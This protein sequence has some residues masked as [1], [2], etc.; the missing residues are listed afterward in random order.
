MQ[1]S[2]GP[3]AHAD[4]PAGTAPP[5]RPPRASLVPFQVVALRARQGNYLG[6]DNNL[7]REA[8]ALAGFVNVLLGFDQPAT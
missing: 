7:R 8:A 1:D 2:A 6:G 5:A 4:R 3:P